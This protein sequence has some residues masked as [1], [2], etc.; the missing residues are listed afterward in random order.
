MTTRINE[1]CFFTGFAS[2]APLTAHPC[3]TTLLPQEWFHR[4]DEQRQ[5]NPLWRKLFS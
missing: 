1:D 4:N 2:Y 3:A 5:V